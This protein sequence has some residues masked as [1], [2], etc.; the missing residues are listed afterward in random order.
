MTEIS[1]R[2]TVWGK[3]NHEYKY[4]LNESIH[5]KHKNWRELIY[6]FGSMGSL[7][8]WVGQF[9]KVRRRWLLGCYNVR[10]FDVGVILTCVKCRS[11]L[12]Y[13]K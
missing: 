4:V 9:W 8:I 10:F 11:S 1:L 5:K 2:D 3:G 12:I 7:Y 6:A 13:D